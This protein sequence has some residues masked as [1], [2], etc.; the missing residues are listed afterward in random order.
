MG[1]GQLQCNKNKNR[2]NAVFQVFEFFKHIGQQEVK[3]SK[4]H[5]R[6]DIGA[7]HN[8]GISCH[9]KNGRNAIQCKQQIGK[10]NSN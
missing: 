10:F 5:Y 2:K 4:S 1:G 3:A 8:K 9:S 6:E 7:K